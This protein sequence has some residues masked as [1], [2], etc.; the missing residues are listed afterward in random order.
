MVGILG[1]SISQ[2]RSLTMF[3]L[4]TNKPVV[5]FPGNV[6]L[7]SWF[8]HLLLLCYGHKC[9]NVY[10]LLLPV[11]PVFCILV[12]FLHELLDCIV[13]SLYY[14]CSVVKDFQY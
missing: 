1:N 13:C 11:V 5:M 12:R 6:S 3:S 10:S 7:Y 9:I 8:M 14:I 4:F 2:Y